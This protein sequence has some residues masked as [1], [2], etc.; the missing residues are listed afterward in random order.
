[1]KVTAFRDRMVELNQEITWVPAHIKDGSFGKWL[2][3]ARDWSISRNRFW[4]SP[5]PV[6]KSDDPRYPRVDVYGS[7]D[8]LGAGL[9]RP[10]DRPPP[11]DA[12]TSSSRPNPDD[13]TG[14]SMMRRVPEVLDC[15]FE[16][17][18]MPYAQV[19]YPFENQEWFEDHF[20]GDFIVEY[21]GQT[22]GWFYTLHVL[23]T[24]L[25][26][27]PA[28]RTCISHGIVLGDDGQKMSKSLRNYPDPFEVFD[29]YGADAM[30]WYLLSS[31]V[32]RGGDLVVTERASA[33]PCARCCCR[34][35]TRG[36]SSRST[37]TPPARSGAC[38]PTATDVLDR[39]LLAKTR[40][41]VDDR[42]RGDGRLRPATAPARPCAVHL[43]ALKNWY[44]RRS[45]SR[46]WA[47][48]QDA[49]DTLHT[50]LVT[51]C[52]VAAPLLP[53]VTEHIYR[54]ADR[55]ASVHLPT[56]R[57]PAALP[58]DRGA[59]GGHGPRPRGVLG[60]AQR[61]QGQRRCG[62]AS[63]WRRSPWPRPTPRR[64]APFAGLIAD[65]VNVK[66]VRLVGR[67][68]LGR[69]VASCRWS[70]RSPARGSVPT[71]SASSAPSR[72]GTG[73]ATAAGRG[74]RDRARGGRVHASASSPRTRRPAPRSPAATASSSLDLAVTEELATEGLAR[75]LVRLVQQARRDAGLDVSDRIALTVG[76]PDQVRDGTPRRR[77]GLHRPGDPRHQRH[78]GD[79]RPT[80]QPLS[81]GDGPA[82]VGVAAVASRDGGGGG[83]APRRVRSL[84]PQM[85]A[86]AEEA[87]DGDHPSQ[88]A[89]SPVEEGAPRPR[90]RKAAA[91]RAGPR[92][93]PR[94]AEEGPGGQAA[95]RGEGCPPK[96][97][98]REGRAGQEAPAARRGRRDDQGRR[99]RRATKPRPPRRR[100]QGGGQ[101]DGS[102]QL[103]RRLP[104]VAEGPHGG[105]SQPPRPGQRLEDEAAELMEDLDPGDVQFDDESGEGDSLVVERERDLALLGAGPPDDQDIDAALDPHQ[106]RHVR[107][108][109]RLRPPHPA[110]SA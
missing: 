77:R 66:D 69:R 79:R 87:C 22:R 42:H 52:R 94:Q 100:P 44:I 102:E 63:R 95:P 65:E 51:L 5:I 70:P 84:V 17:G 11:P 104:R 4:G 23:A 27:R 20:P 1:M 85:P 86:P 57:T 36:P 74:R 15:W 55:G 28:F 96:S 29:T 93:Q 68:R 81:L 14:Q 71:C 89:T 72:P 31:P 67:R 59:R 19:H 75:D 105:A 50:V 37:P 61:P 73:T 64:L 47:G 106:G 82:S 80:A 7:L 30:R 9:R 35:G 25:F 53:L 110:R 40:E 48:D 26:D 43:D 3:N 108:L 8:E 24:A 83:T 98:R 54:G 90:R 56:G 99:R 16:S 21:I 109:G 60:G 62:C 92:R 34:C 12:S 41:L 101:K 78:V 97:R 107:A 10:S 2:A 38:G 32:L 18:S 6:W 46:F 49:I 39:Y 88:E 45:R 13:P 58:A 76:L 33:T 91:A 103:R